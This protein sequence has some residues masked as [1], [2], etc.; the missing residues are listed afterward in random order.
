MGGPMLEEVVLRQAMQEKAGDTARAKTLQ[1]RGDYIYIC[2][3]YIYIYIYN[4]RL[5]GR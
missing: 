5:I 1:V 3:V 2:N 4:D